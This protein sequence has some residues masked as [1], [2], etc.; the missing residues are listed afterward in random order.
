MSK[1]FDDTYNSIVSR[2]GCAMLTRDKLMEY[3]KVSNDEI[4][5]L[6]KSGELIT[7]MGGKRF[8]A[9]DIAMFECPSNTVNVLSPAPAPSVQNTFTN[10]PPRPIDYSGN[11]R[12]PSSCSLNE[13]NMSEEEWEFMSRA[14]GWKEKKAYYNENRDCW[15]MAFDEGQHPDGRRKRKVITAKTENEVYLKAVQYEQERQ[16]ANVIQAAPVMQPMTVNP[17]NVPVNNSMPVIANNVVNM[18]SPKAHYL[19]TDYFRE[20]LKNYPKSID[21]KTLLGYEDIARKHIIPYFE[22]KKMFEITKSTVSTYLKNL[23]KLEYEKGGK[24]Q[25]YSQSKIYDL[26]HGCFEMAADED[27]DYIY[28]RNFVDKIPKPASEKIVEKK[29]KR[30]SD[31]QIQKLLEAVK[32]VEMIYIWVLVMLY[33]GCRPSEA[34]GLTFSK[35]DFENNKIL[36]NQTIG[37]KKTTNEAGKEVIVPCVKIIRKGRSK[38]P[39]SRTIDVGKEL[40]DELAVY[41]DELKKD[42]N[43]MA[44]KKANGIEDHLFCGSKGQLWHYYDYK[45]K[46]DRCIEYYNR[47]N[48]DKADICDLESLSGEAVFPYRFRAN[49]ATRALKS[50]VD[51]KTTQEMLGHSTPDMVMYNYADMGESDVEEATQQMASQLNCIT[52]LGSKTDDRSEATEG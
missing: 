4:D 33:T 46:F 7:V 37:V 35:L 25:L 41:I 22:G 52:S 45:Q 51:M 10:E 21:D 15:C 11:Q 23:P 1:L 5:E 34:L 28:V 17:A 39:Q 49:Y 14:K 12:Y 31:K 9:Y 26:I 43:M 8:K 42:K 6:I 50:G 24:K 40:M 44:L 48:K 29:K 3:W 38:Q 27:E 19:F 47:G 2:F 16:A 13:F 30:F 20:Y 36:F 32:P 18:T